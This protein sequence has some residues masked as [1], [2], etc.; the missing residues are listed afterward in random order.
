MDSYRKPYFQG[1]HGEG[2]CNSHRH[3]QGVPK[4]STC[5]HNTLKGTAKS[6]RKS[7][8]SEKLVVGSTL[9]NGGVTS[10]DNGFVQMVI[11]I[12]RNGQGHCNHQVNLLTL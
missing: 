4:D 7:P 9:G 3:H 12:T 2:S 8:P 11:S 1:P 5:L 6:G 10:Y